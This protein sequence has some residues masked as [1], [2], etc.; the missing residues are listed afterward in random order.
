MRCV[1]LH[2]DDQPPVLLRLCP[3]PEEATM[4]NAEERY[5]KPFERSTDYTRFR[6]GRDSAPSRDIERV[7][8]EALAEQLPEPTPFD[9]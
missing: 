4:T 6:K 1:G 3:H 5:G 7:R 8:A 9:R 2:G